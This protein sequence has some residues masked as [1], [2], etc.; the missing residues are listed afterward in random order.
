M[1]TK[2]RSMSFLVNKSLMISTYPFST[3]TK[4]GVLYNYVEILFKYYFFVNDIK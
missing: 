2:F 3:A 4:S 1:F